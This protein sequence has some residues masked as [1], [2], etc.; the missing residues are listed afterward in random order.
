MWISNPFGKKKCSGL[1][2]L[3]RTHPSTE[4][5]VDRLRKLDQELNR[6]PWE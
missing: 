4:D 1:V 6:L 2:N 3:F 5:R